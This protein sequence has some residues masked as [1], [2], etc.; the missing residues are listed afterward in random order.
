MIVTILSAAL[1]HPLTEPGGLPLP[2]A[3]VSTVAVCA[4][5]AAARVSPGK[6]LPADAVTPAPVDDRLSP[7]QA[8]TRAVALA[9]FALAIAAGRLGNPDE[10][11]NIAPSLVVGFAWPV[12]VAA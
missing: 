11:N 5:V 8:A 12:L 4:V 9:L 1:A 2:P 3:V 7:A 10:V 6:P